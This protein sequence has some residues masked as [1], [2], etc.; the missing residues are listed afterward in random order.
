MQPL[1]SAS[2]QFGLGRGVLGV[3]PAS[4]KIPV[5]PDDFESIIIDELGQ[6][7]IA[8]KMPLRCKVEIFWIEPP[9]DVSQIEVRINDRGHILTANLASVAFVASHL[10]DGGGILGAIGGELD[11]TLVSGWWGGVGG[12][13]VHSPGG[14][15]IISMSCSLDI[16]AAAAV[17]SITAAAR[18]RLS[19]CS[20]R[21]SCSIVPRATMRYTITGL[22]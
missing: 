1:V 8:S 2:D 5:D 3:E 18:S 22:S 7:G 13:G 4:I 12:V 15:I 9:D 10:S 17:P 11:P 14:V 16:L 21:I 20:R 19:P 6:L